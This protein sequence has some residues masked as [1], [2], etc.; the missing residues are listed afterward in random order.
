MLLKGILLLSLGATYIT[1]TTPNYG[2]VHVHVN[3]V[4]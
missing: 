1:L 2:L 3:Y 4:L